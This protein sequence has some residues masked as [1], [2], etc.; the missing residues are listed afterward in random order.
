MSDMK[1]ETMSE[2]KWELMCPGRHRFAVPGGWLYTTN[3]SPNEMLAFVPTPPKLVRLERAGPKNGTVLIA[4]RLVRAITGEGETASCVIYGDDEDAA[5]FAKGSWRE[6]AAK[7]G[8]AVRS[9]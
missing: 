8:L 7:L 5:V 9:E 1:G 4:P 3:E 6:V 2:T